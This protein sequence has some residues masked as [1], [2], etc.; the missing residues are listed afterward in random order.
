M[1]NQI[2]CVM[3][4]GDNLETARSIAKQLNFNPDE[5]RARCTPQQKS[6]YV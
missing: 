3:L 1:K 2:R 5:V 6:Q 4:T